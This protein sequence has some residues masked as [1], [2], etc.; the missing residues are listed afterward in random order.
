M[1]NSK[2]LKISWLPPNHPQPKPTIQRLPQETQWHSTFR[3]SRGKLHTLFLLSSL[4]ASTPL[5]LHRSCTDEDLYWVDIQ[6]GS[7]SILA[8]VLRAC[9][10]EHMRP[11]CYF[12]G[13]FGSVFSI[14]Q[15]PSPPESWLLNNKGG[16]GPLP[17]LVILLM[18]HS[19]TQLFC[20][21]SATFDSTGLTLSSVLAL[22]TPATEKVAPCPHCPDHLPIMDVCTSASPPMHGVPGPMS[23]SLAHKEPH[24]PPSQAPQS[25]SG[26]RTKHL[27]LGPFQICVSS[28]W[29]GLRTRRPTPQ[30][31]ITPSFALWPVCN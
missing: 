5:W 13:V 21:F 26:S 17:S 31:M 1:M 12:S 19:G 7:D 22:P 30:G 29:L 9:P 27:C 16:T 6:V 15:A 24:P 3:L 11:F 4:G 10:R 20:D 18:S 23:T 28:R 14:E 2:S 25:P 8:A